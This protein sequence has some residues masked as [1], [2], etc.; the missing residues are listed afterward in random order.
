MITQEL[1]ILISAHVFL[2]LTSAIIFYA[3]L[4][5]LLAKRGTNK[6]SLLLHAV[7]SFGTAAAAWLISTLYLSAYYIGKE[8]LVTS[9]DTTTLVPTFVLVRELLLPLLVASALIVLVSVWFK[10]ERVNDHVKLKGGLIILS[11]I[12]SIAAMALT[13]L[14]ILIP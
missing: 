4:L 13:F 11:L 10:G 8:G 1:I 5:K 9:L 6:K 3:L 14:G 12:A 2:L 7:L